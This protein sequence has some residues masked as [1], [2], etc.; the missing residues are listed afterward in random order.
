MYKYFSGAFCQG[1]EKPDRNTAHVK[2]TDYYNLSWVE[3]TIFAS[4]TG[5]TGELAVSHKWKLL[6]VSIQFQQG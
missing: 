4:A 2:K 5:L 3:H 6:R 1:I